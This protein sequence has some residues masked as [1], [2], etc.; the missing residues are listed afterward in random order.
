M[1]VV[2]ALIL[3]F[4]PLF[5]VLIFAFYKVILLFNKT[6]DSQK[7]KIEREY[8]IV[9]PHKESLTTTKLDDLNEREITAVIT[10]AVN[11]YIQQN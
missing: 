3:V 1:I 7:A 2:I 6:Q 8:P 4:S 5:F 9:F 10:A 11:Y